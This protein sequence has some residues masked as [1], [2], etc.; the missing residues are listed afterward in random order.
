MTEKL[1]RTRKKLDVLKAHKLEAFFSKLQTSDYYP[2]KP[3]P[4]MLL[5]LLET[6]G[7]KANN[8]VMVGDT[9]YD[10]SMAHYAGVKSIGVSWGYHSISRLKLMKP[11]AIVNDFQE[12]QKKIM[13]LL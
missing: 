4:T 11:T 13:E 10:I 5:M 6:L 3:D 9:D 2:S 7:I 8:A 12:L 1:A